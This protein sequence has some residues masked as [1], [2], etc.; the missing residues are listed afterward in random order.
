MSIAQ[1]QQDGLAGPFELADK[2]ILDAVSEV[3]IELQALQRAQNLLASLAEQEDQQRHTTL[4]N[5]H[6]A[7]GAMRKLFLDANLQSVVSDYFG[8]DLLLWQTKFFPKYEGVGENKW[9]HDR[10]VENGSD[11]IDIYD[12]S[13]HFSF[14]VALTDLGMDHGRLEY[15]KGSHLPID[16]LDRDMPR[17]FEEMPEV[18]HDRITPLPLKRGEFAL[19][20]SSLLH[21]SLAY[22][23]SEEDW[24]PGYFG[25]PNPELRRNADIRSG[26]ISLAARL[27]RKGTDIPERYGSNPA[28]LSQAIA[29]PVP[30]YDAIPVGNRSVVM[31]FN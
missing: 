12:T 6:M 16:G 30:Y 23:H 22:G 13:N 3:A 19:F 26:R 20:H 1:L 27:A 14:V 5:R 18:V 4:I 17:L 9:H 2:S 25:A 7:F 24:R 10:I 21:R 31:P 8:K 28:G 15:V 29:E 11:P